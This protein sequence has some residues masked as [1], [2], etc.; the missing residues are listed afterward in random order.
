MESKNVST[1]TSNSVHP[2]VSNVNVDDLQIASVLSNRDIVINIDH[3][4]DNDEAMILA[5]GYKQEFKRE[6]S[7]WSIFS[8]SFLTLGLL[9]SIAATFDY[10]QLVVGI[11]PV[12]WLIGLFFVTSVA[13]SLAETAS[14]FPTSAG[15]P[16]AVSQLAPRRVAPLFTWLCAY[17]NWFC[18]ITAAPLVNYSCACLIL[19]L[20]SYNVESYVPTNGQIYGLTLGIQV[21]DG[22]ISSLP[23]IWNAR[24][25]SMGTVINMIFLIIVFVLILGGNKRED[26]HENIPKFND[27]GKAWGLYNQTE[28]P[29][30]LAFLMSFL[31]VIWA[32]SGYDSPFH[33]SEEC[34]N[35][36]VAAP[37]AIVLTSTFGGLVG[38]LFMIAI[39]YTVVDIDTIAAD[40]QGLGQPFITYMTQILGK[41]LV[42]AA[43]ALTIISSFFMGQSCLLSASRVTYAYSRD[44]LFPFSKYWKIVNPFTQTPINAVWFNWVIGQLLLLLIFAGD[45]A[46]GAIFSVGGIA[47]FVSFTL[48]TF[49]KITYARNTFKPGPWNLGRFSQPIGFVSVIFVTVMIPVLCFPYVAGKDLTPD[50]MNWT[51]VVYFG[52]LLIVFIWFIVDAHKWYKG[53]KCNIDESDLVYNKSNALELGQEEKYR[54]QPEERV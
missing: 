3:Q 25:N 38:F 44:G 43:A 54:N 9:P 37:K 34:S 39:A 15:T 21:L 32:M 11:S 17:S 14:A 24:F 36:A 29:T 7:L 31:G 46:I 52:P 26:F 2:V 6:F 23:T 16:Y 30:G 10:Q 4:V 33:L 51:V 40:P 22:I 8:V 47:G 50:E 41:K 45:T 35:A 1:V 20:K 13:Y 48:P 18:Q 53:P 28:F 5:L 42:N 49:F 27:N 19:A 12:P